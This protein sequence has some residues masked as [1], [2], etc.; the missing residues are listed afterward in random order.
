MSNT[1][2]AQWAYYVGWIL[3]GR[4]EVPREVIDEMRQILEARPTLSGD[5]RQWFDRWAGPRVSGLELRYKYGAAMA[6][7]L[8]CA[9]AKP[10][11]PIQ[12]FGKAFNETDV[13][14]HRRQS[15]PLWANGGPIPPGTRI[16][17]DSGAAFTPVGEVT[18]A[19]PNEWHNLKCAHARRDSSGAC[20]ACGIPKLE[21]RSSKCPC[22]PAGVDGVT[23]PDPVTGKPCCAKGGDSA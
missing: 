1:T 14:V 22:D 8:A 3:D 23:C 12:P 19:P 10:P 16:V 9:A 11:A 20:E 15:R 18:S 13:A 4:T 17:G 21:P 2:A 7:W 6:A 5:F